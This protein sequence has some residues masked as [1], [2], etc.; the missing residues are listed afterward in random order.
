MEPECTKPLLN[1]PHCVRTKRLIKTPRRGSVDERVCR[2]RRRSNRTQPWHD[3][4][5]LCSLWKHKAAAAIIGSWRVLTT[6]TE[7]NKY[8]NKDVFWIPKGEGKGAPFI[9]FQKM[10]TPW[11]YPQSWNGASS[12]SKWISGRSGIC[13]PDF[14][15]PNSH[16]LITRLHWGVILLTGYL[17][18]CSLSPNH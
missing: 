16:L 7:Q 12:P 8:V 6:E 5:W 1:L 4:R 14:R 9:T 15:S 11:Q 2:E 3:S 13:N 18:L 17:T 10:I